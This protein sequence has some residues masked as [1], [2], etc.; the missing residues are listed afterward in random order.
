MK[1]ILWILLALIVIA[2]GVYLY[3][4]SA[5]QND[6]DLSGNYT[7]TATPTNITDNNSVSA[8]DT[9][10]ATGT[11]NGSTVSTNSSSPYTM[12]TVATHNSKS[13]CWSIISGKVYDLTGM[14]GKHPGGDDAI[15]A[16]C[17][18]DGSDL[19]SAQHGMSQKVLDILP[20]FY[21]GD[22]SK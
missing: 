10:S 7:N 15:L 13:S 17:G 11:T 1:K 6:N 3:N 5:D 18:K 4:T 19:F 22:L 14:F 2:G 16:I 20:N 9:N 21:L 8:T 12:A